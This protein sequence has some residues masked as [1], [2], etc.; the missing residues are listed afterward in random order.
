MSIRVGFNH[1]YH[2][3]FI[4]AKELIKNKLIGKILYIEQFMVMAVDLIT[5]KNGDLKKIS[6]VV[7]L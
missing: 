4:K 3:A 7:N 2:P 6:G 5:K 1:R